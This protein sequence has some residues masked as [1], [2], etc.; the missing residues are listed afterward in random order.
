VQEYL[1]NLIWEVEC[2]HYEVLM[3]VDALDYPKHDYHAQ[4]VGQKYK[5][6]EGCLEG[7]QA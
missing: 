6:S 1:E 4:P 5:L 3:S 2:D 7:F